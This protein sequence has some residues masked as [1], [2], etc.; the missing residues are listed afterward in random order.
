VCNGIA[1]WS[2][3][4]KQTNWQINGKDI[5]SKKDWIKMDKLSQSISIFVTHVD[6][7]TGK[8]DPTSQHNEKADKL[9]ALMITRNTPWQMKESTDHSVTLYRKDNREDPWCVHKQEGPKMTLKR[10]PRT[11][12]IRDKPKWT[13]TNTFGNY[14]TEQIKQQKLKICTPSIQELRGLHKALGH[15]GTHALFT[16]G[17]LRNIDLSWTKCKQAVEN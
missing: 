15:C 17:Q 3:K 12:V 6:A 10:G 9:A 7:P 14:K 8:G 5:C 16:W 4:W 11:R 13:K 1:V 2:V